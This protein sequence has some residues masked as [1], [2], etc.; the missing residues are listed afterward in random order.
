MLKRLK[1][2]GVSRLAGVLH[3]APVVS[4]TVQAVSG[5]LGAPGLANGESRREDLEEVPRDEPP[6]EIA[7]EGDAE[8]AA[9][10]SQTQRL[11]VSTAAPTVEVLPAITV[12]AISLEG[13]SRYR[14]GVIIDT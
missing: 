11:V 6:A 3:T 13:N 14:A 4:T 5:L 12:D 10:F 8:D 1:I 7:R 9:A 2:M